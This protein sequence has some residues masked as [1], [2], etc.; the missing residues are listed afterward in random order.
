MNHNLLGVGQVCDQGNMML[1]NSKKCEIKKGK[2]G[3]IVAITSKAPN[4]IYILDET[5]KGFSWKIRRELVMAQ[6]IG[7]YK[8]RQVGQDQQKGSS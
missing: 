2:F 5:P 6:M 3:E 7:T 1:F 8:F 4:D